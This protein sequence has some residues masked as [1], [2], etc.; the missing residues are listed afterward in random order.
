[1]T[2]ISSFRWKPSWYQDESAA[3]NKIKAGSLKPVSSKILMKRGVGDR[4]VTISA[5]EKIIKM[6]SQ[7]KHERDFVIYREQMLYLQK[8][9]FNI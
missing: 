1:M 9:I 3:I 7:Q 2:R 5:R 4:K 6:A 8:L